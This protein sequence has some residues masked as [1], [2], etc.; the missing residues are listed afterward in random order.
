MINFKNHVTCTYRTRLYNLEKHIQTLS[1]RITTCF[2]SNPIFLIKTSPELPL[3][4]SLELGRLNLC[5]DFDG[6]F[7]I[8]TTEGGGT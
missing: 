7:G 2:T 6:V 5:M 8:I 3:S 4:L 1:L